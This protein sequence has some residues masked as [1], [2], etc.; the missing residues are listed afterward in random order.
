MYNLRLIFEYAFDIFSLK[1]NFWGYRFS[2]WNVFMYF[3]VA[4]IIL[5]ILYKVFF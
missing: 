4:S 2:M 5:Y 1:L 3:I